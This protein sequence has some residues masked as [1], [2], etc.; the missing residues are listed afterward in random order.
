M[1]GRSDYPAPAIN[2]RGSSL[3]H[4]RLSRHGKSKQNANMCRCERISIFA[5]SM[6]VSAEEG[7]RP[8]LAVL[9]RIGV[10]YAA[11]AEVLSNS[12]ATFHGS[13]SSMRLI[14]WSAMRDS[15]FRRYAS[16]S[17]PLSLALPI[18]L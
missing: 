2:A 17:R 9:T 12:G 5:F 14:G 10:S 7:K 11:L 15:S 13:S 4:E 3:L 18:R 16:G 8:N 1:A 6:M